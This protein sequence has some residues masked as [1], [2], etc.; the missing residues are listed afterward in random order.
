[1]TEYLADNLRAE[2]TL[3]LATLR[4]GKTNPAAGLAHTLQARN[5]ATVL[6]LNRLDRSQVIA[7]VQN[8]LGGN[9]ALPEVDAFVAARAEGLPLFVEELLGGLATT[10]AL[11]R[12]AEGWVAR[13]RLT[14]A[15]RSPSARRSPSAWRRYP[16]IP[17]TWCRSRRSSDG[18]STGSCSPP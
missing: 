14:P 1:M 17:E 8:C 18:G 11:C 4:P 16:P 2:P 10:G 3:L 7:M 13:S 12:E 15:S 6:D 5:T 9:P